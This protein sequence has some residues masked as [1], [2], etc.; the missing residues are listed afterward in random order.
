M[1]SHRYEPFSAVCRETLK[2]SGTSRSRMRR[3]VLPLHSSSTCRK[4]PLPCETQHQPLP[5]PLSP[6]PS[7][8]PTRPPQHIPTAHPPSLYFPVPQHTPHSP[9]PHSCPSQAYTQP[10]PQPSPHN[11]KQPLGPIAAGQICDGPQS[12]LPKNLT[13]SLPASPPL[14]PPLSPTLSLLPF[15]PHG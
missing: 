10:F 15:K 1:C 14:L 6:P 13:P 5:R 9:L 8:P 11:T 4:K 3:L 12:R 2:P 7:P